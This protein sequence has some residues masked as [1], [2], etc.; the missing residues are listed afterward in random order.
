VTPDGEVCRCGIN[1]AAIRTLPDNSRG[2]RAGNF[3]GGSALGVS[4]SEGP[5]GSPS[6][7]GGSPSL[8]GG[9]F[10]GGGGAIGGGTS[11]TTA[12]GQTPSGGQTPT[13][14]QHVGGEGPGHEIGNPGNGN[15]VGKAGETPNGGSQASWGNPTDNEPGVRGRSDSLDGPGQSASARSEA[16][17]QNR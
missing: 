1:P 3:S 16:P 6:L 13:G 4:G 5:G 14:G 7:G 2:D 10:S 11:P 8:G 12:G 17:G 15:P 9:G